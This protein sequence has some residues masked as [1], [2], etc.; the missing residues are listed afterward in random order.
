MF[1]ISGIIVITS[2]NERNLNTIQTVLRSCSHFVPK[3]ATG[4]WHKLV[5]VQTLGTQSTQVPFSAQIQQRDLVLRH[6]HCAK[7]L[8][9]AWKKVCLHLF[10]S[11]QELHCTLCSAPFLFIMLLLQQIIATLMNK[12]CGRV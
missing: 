10:S 9:S 3:H 11:H 12:K 6:G 4:H 1:T 5:C 7:I 8:M 2:T